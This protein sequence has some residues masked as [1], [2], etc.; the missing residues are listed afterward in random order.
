MSSGKYETIID[1]AKPLI[2]AE[3]IMRDIHSACL[4]KKY[5][6]AIQLTIDLITEIRILRSSL[7]IM[8]EW[9]KK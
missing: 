3:Q 1:Y 8:S 7:V 4:D 9:E 6:K 5:D 2:N